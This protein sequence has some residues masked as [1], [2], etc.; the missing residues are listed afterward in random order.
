MWKGLFIHL[1]VIL[2][3]WIY[4]IIKV[5]PFINNPDFQKISYTY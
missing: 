2:L 1:F 5:L 4:P 3:L